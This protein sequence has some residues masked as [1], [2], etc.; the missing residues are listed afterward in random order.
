MAVITKLVQIIQEM[1]MRH[2]MF[3][4]DT[5]GPDDEH[6]MTN[7]QDLVFDTAPASAFGTSVAILVPY[8]GRRIHEVTA[9]M[10]TLGNVAGRRP[11]KLG[12]NVR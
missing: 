6:F 3:N 1:G 8:V 9:A 5:R 7:M 11:G 4:P 12:H 2:P 10:A